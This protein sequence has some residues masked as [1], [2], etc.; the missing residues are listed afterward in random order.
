LAIKRRVRIFYQG[1][2]Q[3]VGFRPHLY[4]LAKVYHLTGWVNND[5]AGVTVEVEGEKKNLELF[6]QESISRPPV[7]A[8]IKKVSKT[9][10]PKAG[11][12]H[13][14]IRKSSRSDVVSTQV[15]ADAA[16]CPDCRRELFDRNDRRY[17]YPFINCTN[18][19]PRFTIIERIPY[20]RPFTTMK[21]FKMCPN[22]Q[23]EYDDPANR[24]FHAQP[25]A[26]PVCGPKL[27]LL[28]RQGKKIPGD[29]FSTAIKFLQKG[30][31][32]SVKSIGGFQL[33][34][35]ALNEKAVAELRR[36][37]L[38]EDKPFALMAPDLRA[39]KKFAT[40]SRAE[41]EMLLSPER[42]IVLLRR[43]RNA[44]VAESVAPLQKNLGFMLPYTPLHHLLLRESRM[45]LVMTSGN[46]SD[47]PIAFEDREAMRRLQNIA[48]FFLTHNRPIF[49]RCDDSVMRVFE[50]KPYP[51]RRARGYVPRPLELV[52]PEKRGLLA[53]GAHLKNTFA[54]AK[55]GQLIVSHHIGD[56]ENLETLRA[57]EQGIEHFKSI[58]EIDPE[59]VVHDLHPDYLSTRYA[60]QLKIPRLAVQHHHAHAA[61][62]MAEHGLSQKVLGVSLDGTGYGTDGHIWGG[63]FLAADYFGFERKA[64]LKYIP[65]P[66][67]EKA[68][69]ESWRMALAWLDRIYGKDLWKL[70]L[71]FLRKID[72]ARAKLALAASAKGINAPLTSSMGR[73]FDAVSAILGVR[74][75]ANY[76]G[77]PA[78]ELEM[79]ADESEAGAYRFDYGEEDAK[80]IIDPEPVLRSVVE[81][82]LKKQS[83]GKISARFHNAVCRMVSEVCVRVRDETGL[84]DIT[85]SGGVFQ[86]WWI[87][88]QVKK[89][90]EKARF[91][92]FTHRLV[93]ANDGGISLGQA[94]IGLRRMK[95][96][97]GSSHAR[98]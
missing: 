17:R 61:S 79:S 42:P 68:V 72:H 41:Q 93:P 13:F 82:L 37:K 71:H 90:L 62:V 95:D 22:C 92:V 10:L 9:E 84:N 38:R 49:S 47:E 74:L 91:R 16:T 36:R 26:C 32:I 15:S 20:D 35:D 31:T 64:H 1:A 11:F 81:D 18:C 34:C 87:L 6:F 29:P 63:E 23:A 27:S 56:L 58:F 53:V 28:D 70:E 67:G 24:R 59:M 51:L 25:N 60:L 43:K 66:G 50:S 83:P 39:I 78:I 44:R 12:K 21:I 80:I 33:A 77:Q 97:L 94:A 52:F 86:N 54:L 98:S 57:F 7:L 3:G 14:V 89:L 55:A 5:P 73:L 65:M 8:R 76:E 45:L 2:V 88:S 85:L 30:K 19:G 40:V 4:R 48:D 46:L 69:R 75:F 96:V